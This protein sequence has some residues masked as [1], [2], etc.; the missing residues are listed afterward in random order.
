MVFAPYSFL[1]CSLCIHWKWLCTVPLT[2][3]L[4]ALGILE[5][6]I[7]NRDL[8]QKRKERKE[9]Q[10]AFML[11]SISNFLF[12]PPVLPQIWHSELILCDW[13]WPIDNRLYFL[14]FIFPCLS[15]K[16]SK[17]LPTRKVG[18]N[19]QNL[20]IHVGT[21]CKVTFSHLFKK[22][23]KIW[24]FQ[25]YPFRTQSEKIVSHLGMSTQPVPI[26]LEAANIFI[27]RTRMKISKHIF[28]FPK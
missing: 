3:I 16:Q 7:L 6:L 8:T 15:Q 14:A 24:L 5:P 4:V 13:S 28:V 25:P 1:Q 2:W 27:A 22:G 10:G 21:V 17:M 18:I 23:G 20:N 11:I 9:E 19:L 26:A 12:H